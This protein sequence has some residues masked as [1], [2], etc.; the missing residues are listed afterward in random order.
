M[1]SFIYQWLAENDRFDDK[2]L[3]WW[4]KC[5]DHSILTQD[6]DKPDLRRKI[7]GEKREERLK[8][9]YNEMYQNFL[10]VYKN[11]EKNIMKTKIK[12]KKL[13]DLIGVR[14]FS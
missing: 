4:L 7:I 2:E 8:N 12:N 6:A 13:K 14:H 3:Y 1:R 9:H 11:L 5:E 10:K